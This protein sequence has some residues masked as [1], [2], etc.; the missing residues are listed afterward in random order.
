MRFAPLA[1]I[2]LVLS[3]AVVERSFANGAG[4][5]DDPQVA[6]IAQRVVALDVDR[7]PEPDPPLPRINGVELTQD[8]KDYYR[9]PK[10]PA[11]G[12]LL[13]TQGNILTTHY[14]VLGGL[15]RITVRKGDRSLG[16]AQLVATDLLDDLALVRLVATQDE[17]RLGELKLPDLR[18]GAKEELRTGS[19]LIAIGCS[20]EPTHPTVTM[21]IV[22]AMARNGGR[23]LQTDAE[24]NYGNVGGP[25][26]DI[27]GRVVGL[28]CFV[29]HTFQ[30]WGFNSG[31]GFGTTAETIQA[32]LPRLLAGEKI[33]KPKFA[34]LGV[35]LG[36]NARPNEPGCVIGVVSDDAPAKKA[37][38]QV[39]DS[40]LTIDNAPVHDYLELRR[41]LFLRQP[42]EE[43][44]VKLRRGEEEKELRVRLAERK[45]P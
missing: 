18:W 33:P 40:I 9:R 37:G 24:L 6:A 14:N 25:L 29:G 36:R 19:L 2:L 23:A 20:P 21:G 42:G 13:D 39:G 5:L 1:P 31:I 3:L 44:T 32:V 43:V 35:G 7:D 11:T 8:R 26:I 10:G 16:E 34:F 45:E 38:I 41:L 4:V 28:S 17:L 27:D 12:L 22:S 30:M 15:R